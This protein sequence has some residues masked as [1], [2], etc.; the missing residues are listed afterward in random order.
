MTLFQIYHS[1]SPFFLVIFWCQRSPL[2]AWI[3]A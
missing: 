2:F 1:K 3:L